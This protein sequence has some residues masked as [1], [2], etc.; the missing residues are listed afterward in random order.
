MNGDVCNGRSCCG[1]V[2][3]LLAWRAPDNIARPNFLFRA[4]FA[5][6][7]STPRR[8][9]QGL[10]ERMGV[11]RGAGTRFERDTGAL[12]MCRIGGLK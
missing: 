12:D 4:A 11:P 5:L 2:P 9:D 10:A 3:V 6:H 1:T 8:H 7:P